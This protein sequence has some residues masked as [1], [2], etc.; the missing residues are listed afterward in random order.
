[1]H[2]TTVSTDGPQAFHRTPP[3]RHGPAMLGFAV[4]LLAGALWCWACYQAFT[5]GLVLAWAGVLVS[6]QTV[7]AW[8]MDWRL[9]IGPVARARQVYGERLMPA[10]MGAAL[11]IAV[12]IAA[13][14][15]SA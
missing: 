7:V 6:A 10:L 4:L 2:P 9:Y 15:H 8:D 1:M 3:T 14:V 5:P 12:C 11:Y 13:A